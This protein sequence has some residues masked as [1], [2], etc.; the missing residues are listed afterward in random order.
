MDLYKRSGLLFLFLSLITLDIQCVETGHRAMDWSLH[1][2][3]IYREAS[4]HTDR[5]NCLR[6]S[7]KC[8]DLS[9]L[10]NILS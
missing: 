10:S 6:A 3:T 5:R 2:K 9:A 1:F 7:L 4:D 8:N